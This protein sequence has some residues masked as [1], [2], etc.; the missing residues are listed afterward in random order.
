MSVQV[1]PSKCR[2]V[3]LQDSCRALPARARMAGRVC[4]RHEASLTA[5]K[6]SSVHASWC[7]SIKTGLR[8][9]HIAKACARSLLPN[10]GFAEHD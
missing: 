3:L 10:Q 6:Y 2:V 8:P 7:V 4:R 5:S 9:G 1:L